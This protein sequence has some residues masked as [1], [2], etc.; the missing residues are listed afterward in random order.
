MRKISRGPRRGA[1]SA[2]MS[3]A[4][5][6]TY[7]THAPRHALTLLAPLSSMWPVIGFPRAS[8]GPRVPRPRDPTRLHV[9][10][11]TRHHGEDRARNARTVAP[12]CRPRSNRHHPDAPGSRAT[13]RW[14]FARANETQHSR[15][16]LPSSP[17]ANIA[18]SAARRHSWV[19][20][21]GARPS[22]RPG[23]APQSL[24]WAWHLSRCGEP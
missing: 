7:L 22:S 12:Q 4:R 17:A 18:S 11:V 15:F 6:N 14:P 10:H 3:D 20:K 1:R 21:C 23:L 24:P 8:P 2:E 5:K 16:P 9:T 19:Y 13:H